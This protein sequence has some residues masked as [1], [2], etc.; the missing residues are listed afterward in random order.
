VSKYA[1]YGLAVPVSKPGGSS[2][3]LAT[4]GRIVGL[5]FFLESPLTKEKKKGNHNE[6]GEEW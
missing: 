6:K 3:E 4:M 5:S 2:G 1:V